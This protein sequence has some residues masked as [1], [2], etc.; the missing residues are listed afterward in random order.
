MAAQNQEAG[1]KRADCLATTEDGSPEAFHASIRPNSIPHYYPEYAGKIPHGGGCQ[2]WK[3]GMDSVWSLDPETIRGHTFRDVC[4]WMDRKGSLTF[5]TKITAKPRVRF[6]DGKPL[7]LDTGRALAQWASGSPQPAAPKP[8]SKDKAHRKEIVAAIQA[9]SSLVSLRMS[10]FDSRR[11]VGDIK[12]ASQKPMT[13]SWPLMK[14]RRTHWKGND[15][16]T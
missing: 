10:G 9:C 15:I 6:A 13:T 3:E 4:S 14:P 2:E 1:E 8:M 16:R 11:D 5:A 12:A 7:T